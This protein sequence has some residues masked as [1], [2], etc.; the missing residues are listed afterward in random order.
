M[1]SVKR[2]ASLL[3]ALRAAASITGLSFFPV[4]ML[5]PDARLS[6]PMALEGL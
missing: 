6:L 2:Q 1:R 5:S 3:E 4:S